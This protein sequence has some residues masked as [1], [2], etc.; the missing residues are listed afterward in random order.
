[1]TLP[2]HIDIWVLHASAFHFGH[3][4]FTAG[5]KDPKAIAHQHLKSLTTALYL[6]NGFTL[7]ELDAV[8]LGGDFT[9]M[10]SA[11]GF[12]IAEHFITMLWNFGPR[13]QSSCLLAIMTCT[14]SL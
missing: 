12:A 5:S 2:R 8:V 4:S 14:L 3:C 7:K 13:P 6:K 1:M 11:F 9:W 10:E